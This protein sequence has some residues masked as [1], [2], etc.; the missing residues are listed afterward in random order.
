M[1]LNLTKDQLHNAAYNMG[2]LGDFA[3]YIGKAYMQADSRNQRRLL[4][5]FP[6][7]FD[8]AHEYVAAQFSSA[9]I[10]Y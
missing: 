1:T 6:D 7:L 3:G 9:G 4:E 2:V 5:A 10:S 8:Q